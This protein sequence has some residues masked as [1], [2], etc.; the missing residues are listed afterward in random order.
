MAHLAS[1]YASYETFLRG[2]D[3]F[4]SVDL[5]AMNN[6][7][8]TGDALLSVNTEEDGTRYLN[9]SISAAGL[10]PDVR[11]AQHVHGTFDAE[12]NPSD[13]RMPVIADDADQDGF[14]E[15]LEG[16]A[17]YGDILLPLTDGD[18]VLPMTRSDGTMNFIQSYELGDDSN[19]FSPVSGNDYTAADLMPLEN[20]EIVLHGQNVG[21][22]FGDG[23]GGEINGSQDGYVGLLPVAAG[24]I[25]GTNRAQALDILED[26]FQRASETVRLGAGDDVFD[27]GLGNDRIYGGKGTDRIGGGADD[28]WLWGR[29]QN[30]VLRGDGGDDHLFGNKGSDRLFGDEGDDHLKGHG[31]GDDLNGGSGNDMLKGHRGDDMLNGGAGRDMLKGHSGDDVLTGGNGRDVLTGGAGW[32]EFVYTDM[33]EGR[34]RITDFEDGIDLISLNTLGMDFADLSISDAARGARVEFGNTSILLEGVMAD[35][36][37]QS[38]FIF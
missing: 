11:H 26:Q 16:L 29:S 34:D 18:G 8:V 21:S 20:R 35:Q 12:G 17:A 25:E 33:R 15:V 6:S 5:G 32:D 36:L 2:A 22:G 3:A 24:E 38:D 7:G 37:D 9:I 1:S 13:A 28:D 14:V 4:W 31:G 30:D 27:G 19:F 10:T 23:T